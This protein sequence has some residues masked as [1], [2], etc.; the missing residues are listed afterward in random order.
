MRER[1]GRIT[2]RKNPVQ[3]NKDFVRSLQDAGFVPY[4]EEDKD[5]FLDV[6]EGE[7]EVFTPN[8]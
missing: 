2:S 3:K 5:N 1:R 8:Y 6:V 4:L 7:H